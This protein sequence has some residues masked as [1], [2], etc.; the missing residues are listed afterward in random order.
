MNRKI[1]TILISSLVLA[2]CS[3]LSAR[4]ATPSAIPTVLADSSII[5][6]GRVEPVRYVNIGLNS[7]GL[8]SDVFVQEGDTVAPGEVIA[9]IQSHDAQTLEGAQAQ[10]SQQLTAAYQ[11]LRDAQY[12]LDN[13]AA[14]SDFLDLTPTEAL[15]QTLEKLNM[16]RDAFEPYRFIYDPRY[17]YLNLDDPHNYKIAAR[18]ENGDALQAKKRLDDAWTMYRKAVQ[19]MELKSDVG[20]AQAN[21]DQALRDYD[22]L[23]DA[24]FREATAGARAALANGEVRA[25]FAGTITNLNLKVGEFASAG[26]PVVT[27]ADFSSWV[28][29]TTDLT[30][31][32][33][34]NIKQGRMVSLTLD[35]IPALKLHGKVQSISANYTEKEGDIDYVVKIA[36]TDQDPRLRWGMTAQVTFQ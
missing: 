13:F 5:A 27:L 33:V 20:T 16:A 23:N 19:W 9:R 31:L 10:A 12:K 22:S 21:L 14:P 28:I 11:N 35:A 30:E 25:P 15:S 4:S 34:V 36:L 17:G 26:Q 18:R 32:D 7:S 8:V 2:S 3:T 1:L 24:S 6:E 29:N